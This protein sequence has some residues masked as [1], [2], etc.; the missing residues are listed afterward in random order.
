VLT[1]ILFITFVL[2]VHVAGHLYVARRLCAGATPRVR[3]ATQWA[4][5][6]QAALIVLAFSL[7][8]GDT[9]GEGWQVPL[10][11]AGMLALGFFSLEMVFLIAIDGSDWIWRKWQTLRSREIEVDPTR[12]ALLLR[13]IR[14][15]A[16]SLTGAI[17]AIGVTQAYGTAEVVEVDV[18]IADLPDA[19]QGF[20]IVQVSDIHVGPTIRRPFLE[21]IVRRVN[22]LEADLVAITGDLMD[23]SVTA[24]GDDM[25][26]IA[27]LESRHGTFFITGNHEYYSGA[28]EWIAYLRERGV[29][30]LLNEHTVLDHEGSDL[31]LAGVTDYRAGKRV[32]GHT[33][34]VE[35]AAR[36]APPCPARI[37]LAHQ[38][39]SAYAAAATGAFDLQLSGHTHGGQYVPFSWLVHIFQP[40]NVGLHRHEGMWI[41]TNRGTGYW[42]PPIRTGVRPEI[43]QVTL[44][45]AT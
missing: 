36:G 41:Y 11:W 18:P 34:D 7:L 5:L 16:L 38:P 3:R 44:R 33:S 30:V 17:S 29:T 6:L 2:F 9:L 1:V 40:F 14:L 26:P 13:P 21:G 8:R 4:V 25:T 32:P 42:G 45:R 24:L 10:Q 43:T 12:R 37:L 15:G 19:L 22:E 39:R 31:L 28:E 23:G 35:K 27:D 20:R